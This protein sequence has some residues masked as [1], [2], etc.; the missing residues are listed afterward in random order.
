MF[1]LAS[2]HPCRDERTRTYKYTHMH[3]TCTHRKIVIER[4]QDVS[5]HTP[6][7]GSSPDMFIMLQDHLLMSIK[8]TEERPGAPAL[9]F[10]LLHFSISCQKHRRD[11][12]FQH[13]LGSARWG[14]WEQWDGI[15]QLGSQG[16][17]TPQWRNQSSV[18]Q[19]EH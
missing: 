17:R 6:A 5:F 16:Q 11:A 18:F 3:T 13:W 4:G 2:L 10:A 14:T 12:I 7:V 8:P 15:A 1:L 19:P 9:Q